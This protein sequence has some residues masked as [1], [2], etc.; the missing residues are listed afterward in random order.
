MAFAAECAALS[1]N[2]F[3]DGQG[4]EAQACALCTLPS[5]VRGG[6]LRD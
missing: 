4:E 3:F 2:E 6:M 5:C 1:L